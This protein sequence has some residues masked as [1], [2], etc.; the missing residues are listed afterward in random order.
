MTAPSKLAID[1]GALMR[2]LE[3]NWTRAVQEF[4][5]APILFTDGEGLSFLQEM[6]ML[7]RT[8]TKMPHDSPTR[9]SPKNKSRFVY[10]PG[11]LALKQRR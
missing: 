1:L 6:K 10:R 9:V 2:D 8:E 3:A 11:C 4:E 5:H 7:S